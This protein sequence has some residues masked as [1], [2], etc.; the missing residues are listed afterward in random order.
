MNSNSFEFLSKIHNISMD[1][2]KV[3]LKEN[4][5]SPFYK[6]N[7]KSDYMYRKSLTVLLAAGMVLSTGTVFAQT[8]GAINAQS[9]TAFDNK[10]IKKME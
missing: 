7:H 10:V 6:E 5:K 2:A 3:L 9:D 8:S 1:E 4:N